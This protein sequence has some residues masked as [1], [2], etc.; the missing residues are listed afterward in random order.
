MADLRINT[1][2]PTLPELPTSSLPPV[3]TTAQEPEVEVNQE[4]AKMKLADAKLQE[5]IRQERILRENLPPNPFFITKETVANLLSL[6]GLKTHD[7]LQMLIPLVKSN[8][9]PPISNYF[10]GCTALG[11][12]GNI[13]VGVNVEFKGCPINQA[14][15]GEQ[16]LITNARQHGETELEA[17]AISAAPCGHCRQFMNEIGEQAKFA[18]ITPN[19]PSERLSTLLPR[20]FGPQDLKLVGGLLTALGDTQKAN[21]AA[22]LEEAA[23]LASALSYVPY[24]NSPSG[25]AIRTNDG[26]IYTGCCLENAAYNPSLSPLQVA[27]VALISDMRPYSDIV[28]VYLVER[29]L[30]V[31]QEQTTK[32]VLQSIAPSVELQV[33]KL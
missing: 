10:V 5:T 8:A 30:N 18:I 14:V 29:P 25:V 11:K 13:Y 27:L 19:T 31:S 3:L 12:S 17:I 32:M 26:K 20:S 6:T 7:L 4:L 23:T 33:K 15:H 21:Q 16:F 22:T 28:D 1:L 24:T 9:R 2:A